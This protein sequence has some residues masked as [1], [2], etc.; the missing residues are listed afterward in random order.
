MKKSPLDKII[1]IIREDAPTNAMAHGKIAGS[2]E[3]GDDPPVRKKKK[4]YAYGGHGSRRV[5]LD[6]FKKQN[7]RAN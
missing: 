4:N 5:W 2:A 6:Y 7:G 3:A 1:Q